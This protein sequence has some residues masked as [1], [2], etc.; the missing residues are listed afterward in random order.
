MYTEKP[1]VT[2]LAVKVWPNPSE[3]FFTVNVAGASNEQVVMT[4]Y[5]VYGKQV[6]VTNASANHDYRFGENFANGVYVLEVRQGNNRK[7]VKLVKQ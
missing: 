3:R 2:T 1:D 4:V 6:Y 5:D 7:T